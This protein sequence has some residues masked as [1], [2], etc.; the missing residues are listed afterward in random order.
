VSSLQKRQGTSIVRTVVVASATLAIL[1]VCFWIY[2]LTQTD[3]ETGARVRRGRLPVLIEDADQSSPDSADA[4]ADAGPTVPFEGGAVIG[5]G[6]RTELS[7]YPPEGKKAL[8][9]ISFARRQERARCRLSERAG[10]AW[11]SSGGDL[12]TTL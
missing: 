9:E 3:S 5:R 11:M 1:L 8:C 6:G 2:E 12:P 7:L 4:E 10:D